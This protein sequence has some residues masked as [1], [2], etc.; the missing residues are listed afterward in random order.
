MTAP[1]PAPPSEIEME[2][3]SAFASTSWVALAMIE[4]SFAPPAI[5]LLSSTDASTAL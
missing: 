2:T 5:A 1:A 4:R 3:T